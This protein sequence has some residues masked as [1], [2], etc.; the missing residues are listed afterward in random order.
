MFTDI[1][2]KI[3]ALLT[4]KLDTVVVTFI[5]IPPLQQQFLLHSVVCPSLQTG[6]YCQGNRVVSIELVYNNMAG[7]LPQSLGKLSALQQLVF[8]SNMITGKLCALKCEDGQH[9]IWTEVAF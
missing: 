5:F 7:P 2:F 6:V 8:Y 3:L 9:V 4:E 1:S